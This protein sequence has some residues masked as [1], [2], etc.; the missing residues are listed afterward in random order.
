MSPP[1][2]PPFFTLRS[3]AAPRYIPPSQCRFHPRIH[4][5]DGTSS[6]FRSPI[7]GAS[8]LPPPQRSE[9]VRWLAISSRRLS[10]R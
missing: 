3:V 5:P 9:G 10:Q 7:H 1:K 2:H 6:P 4:S 8:F